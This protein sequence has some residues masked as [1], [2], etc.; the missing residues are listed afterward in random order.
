MDRKGGEIEVCVVC[1]LLYSNKG[2]TTRRLSDRDDL[3][4]MLCFRGVHLVEDIRPRTSRLYR[5]TVPVHV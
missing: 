4:V 3:D 1:S 2:L 5:M